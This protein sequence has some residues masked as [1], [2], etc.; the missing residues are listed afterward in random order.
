MPSQTT[1]FLYNPDKFAQVS[2]FTIAGLTSLCIKLTF[3]VKI[4]SEVYFQTCLAQQFYKELVSIKKTSQKTL[5]QLFSGVIKVTSR[6]LVRSPSIEMLHPGQDWFKKNFLKI[7]EE[8]F[9]DD[10]CM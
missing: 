3:T 7:L 10:K 4:A 1:S 2:S 5:P 9:L 6:Q 8:V